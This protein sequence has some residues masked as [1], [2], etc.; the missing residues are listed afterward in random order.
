MSQDMR[1]WAFP[2][3]RC[4]VGEDWPC[5]PIGG[6]G[7]FATTLRVHRERGMSP[8]QLSDRGYKPERL[9]DEAGFRLTLWRI[10][11]SPRAFPP[12]FERQPEVDG[13]SPGPVVAL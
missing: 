9:V 8:D 10:P 5:E 11:G 12:G 13:K 4:G 6:H 3:P 1:L 7:K 2:C